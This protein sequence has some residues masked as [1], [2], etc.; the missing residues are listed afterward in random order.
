MR[1]YRPA[2]QLRNELESQQITSGTSLKPKVEW[3]DGKDILQAQFQIDL[4]WPSLWWRDCSRHSL[5]KLNCGRKRRHGVLDGRNEGLANEGGAYDFAASMASFRTRAAA[6]SG[7]ALGAIVTGTNFET[8]V[9]LWRA[10]LSIGTS[11]LAS[12]K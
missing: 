3:K 10:T 2:Y 11:T 1:D 7:S 4:R 9:L 6:F 12:G 8:G 5:T